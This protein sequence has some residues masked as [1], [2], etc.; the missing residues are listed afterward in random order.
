[1][2]QVPESQLQGRR[3][4]F[5]ALAVV[6]GGAAAG[7]VAS[8]IGQTEGSSARRPLTPMPAVP[9]AFAPTLRRMNARPTSVPAVRT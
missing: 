2:S 8:Q 9:V 3:G 5:R 6:V 7:L 1:M 4:F